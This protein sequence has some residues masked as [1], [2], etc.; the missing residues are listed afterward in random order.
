MR[1]RLCLAAFTAALS[2]GDADA[3]ASDGWGGQLTP[4]IWGAGLSGDVRP[5]AG[6]PT[7]EVEESVFEV[8]D[9][10]EGAFFLTGLAIRDD[11]VLVGDLSW[12]S[13]GRT[14]SPGPGIPPVK[15]SVDMLFVTLAGGKRVQAQRDQTID[16]LAGVRLWDIDAD[17]ALLGTPFTASRSVSLTDPVIGIR[18]NRQH[19][20]GFSTIAYGDIGGF[21]IGS[22]FTAQVAVTV[23]YALSEKAYVSGGY[24]YVHL[25]YENNGALI[26]IRLSGPLLGLTWR[27]G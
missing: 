8:L 2:L 6:G 13:S 1:L 23:N 10:L 17:A 16:F 21:G 25:D 7:L 18:F 12:S 3:Q 11:I 15:G 5:L 27:F 4:Y 14:E 26:D 19:T 20:D 22:D 24:R 9:D